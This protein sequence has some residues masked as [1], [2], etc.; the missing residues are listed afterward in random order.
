MHPKHFEGVQWRMSAEKA[1]PDHGD[2]RGRHHDLRKPR[3][4]FLFDLAARDAEFDQCAHAAEAARHHFAVVEVGDR[5][6]SRPL[7]DDQTHEVATPARLATSSSRVAANPRAMNSSIA[8]SMM[9]PRRSAARS[10]RLEAGLGDTAAAD[11]VSPARRLAGFG[12]A[13][14]GVLLRASVMIKI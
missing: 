1:L 9:A 5:W 4:V 10:A 14:L 11:A 12:A 7:G 8:A 2:Q 13:F 6:K 3:Q